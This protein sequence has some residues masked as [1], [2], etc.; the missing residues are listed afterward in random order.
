MFLIVLIRARHGGIIGQ[1]RCRASCAL[2]CASGSRYGSFRRVGAV[3][4]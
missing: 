3:G 4:A 1:S 2:A